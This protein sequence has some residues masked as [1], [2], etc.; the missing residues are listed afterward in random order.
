LNDKPLMGDHA[1]TR[2]ENIANWSITL[3]VIII[4]TAYGVSVL[5]PEIFGSPT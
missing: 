1:N 3:F 4:L 5:F 2:W